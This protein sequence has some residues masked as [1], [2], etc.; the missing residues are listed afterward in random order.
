MQKTMGLW[1]KWLG[2]GQGN[3]FVGIMASFGDIQ[4]DFAEKA[5]LA[6]IRAFY[7]VFLKYIRNE[8]P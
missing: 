1:N 3:A 5:I 8:A 2:K 7:P 4:E 6:F